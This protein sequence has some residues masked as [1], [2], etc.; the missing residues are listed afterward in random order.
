M[1]QRDFIPDL[2]PLEF[3]MVQVLWRTGPAPAREVQDRYNREH[4]DKPLA[5][6]TVMTLL[7]RLVDK[8]VLSVD[9]R[10]QPFQ[11]SPLITK[12]RLIGQRVKDFVNL[13]FDGRP[14]DLAV[15]LVEEHAL[16]ADAVRRLEETLEK[17]RAEGETDTRFEE[18]E[19]E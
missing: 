8:K 15:R 1:T 19:E 6:T 2:G 5:Y 17:T 14:A 12:D 3:E 16:S 7:T 4:P 11:F 18:G 10:R 13:F 9:R